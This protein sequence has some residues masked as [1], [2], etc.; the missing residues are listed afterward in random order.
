M[1][2]QRELW[3]YEYSHNKNKWNK[4]TIDLPRILKNRRVL[5]LGVGNGKTLRAILKQ[6]PSEVTAVYFSEKVIRIVRDNFREIKFYNCDVRELP[7]SNQDFDVVV[8]YYVLNNLGENDRLKVVKEMYRVLKKNGIILFE[9]FAIGDYR[10][11]GEEIEK[12]TVEHK[13]GII[14]HF[15]TEDEAKKLF[16]KF[17]I[18][19]IKISERLPIKKDKSIKRRIISGKFIK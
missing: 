8:C 9:D 16:S 15:F 14:C 3:D 13:N 18:R 4:E 17:L 10:Q 11:K 12:N 6:K 19:E 1:K 7:F 2:S 5:E